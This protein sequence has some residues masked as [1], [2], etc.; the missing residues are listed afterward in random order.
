MFTQ[1][2]NL[3]WGHPDSLSFLAIAILMCT[4]R[5]EVSALASFIGALNDERF[6]LALPFIALWWWPQTFS[7]RQAFRAWNSQFWGIGIGLL[8]WFILRIALTQ[9]WI[10]DPISDP[11]VGD[12]VGSEPLR[13]LLNPKEWPSLVVMVFLGYRWLW[14]T[15]AL[16]IY[17]GFSSKGG[18]DLRIAC[19]ALAIAVGIVACFSMADISRSLAFVFPIVLIGVLDIVKSPLSSQNGVKKLLLLLLAANV[20]TPAAIVF[21]GPGSY[22]LNPLS[23]WLGYREVIADWQNQPILPLPLNLWQFFSL[24]QGAPSL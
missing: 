16:A 15:P 1:W 2:T 18:F 23:S 12:Y 6:L 13:R 7:V 20:V 17:V 5:V 11:Y 4:K 3:Y 8:C 19:Y 21:A 10:G 24:P 22:W 9:G 14:V